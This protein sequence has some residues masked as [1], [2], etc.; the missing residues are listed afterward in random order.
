M[1][2]SPWK[3]ESSGPKFHDLSEII[4]N[5]QNIIFFG[6]DDLEGASTLNLHPLKLHSE[7]PNYTIRVNSS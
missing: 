5:F 3:K 4:M 6:F 7:A 2:I 1:A